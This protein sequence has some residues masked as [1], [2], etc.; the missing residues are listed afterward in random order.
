MTLFFKAFMFQ[1]FMCIFSF[2]QMDDQEPILGLLVTTVEG[3]EKRLSFRSCDVI[4]KATMIVGDK[5]QFNISTNSVT[6]EECAVNVEILP[7]TF[8]TDS[9]EQRKIVS[10]FSCGHPW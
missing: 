8:Q 5:V 10:V 9:E 3:T 6:K 2:E 7:E 1:L 4:T